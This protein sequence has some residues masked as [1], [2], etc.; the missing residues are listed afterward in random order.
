MADECYSQ[1]EN[2]IDVCISTG[3]PGPKG[4]VGTQTQFIFYAQDG[5]TTVSGND[6]SGNLMEVD[7]DGC[8]VS[9]NGVLLEPGADYQISPDGL[10]ITF[11]D[12]I[13]NA[14]NVVIVQ[15]WESSQEAENAVL[16]LKVEVDKNTSDIAGLDV[17][18]TQNESDIADLQADQTAQVVTTA[19]VVTVG[20]LPFADPND[21]PK[22]QQEANWILHDWIKDSEKEIADA[23]QEFQG[24]DKDVSDLSQTV[25]DLATD[26]DGISISVATNTINISKNASDIS[27]LQVDVGNI[28]VPDLGPLDVRVTDLETLTVSHSSDLVSLRTD[29]D[30]LGAPVDLGPLN[31]AISD[32]SVAIAKNASDIASIKAVDAQQTGQINDLQVAVGNLEAIDHDHSNHALIDQDNVFTVSQTIKDGIRLTGSQAFIECDTGTPLSVRNNNF[33][34]AV[35]N[36]MR[37]NGDVAIS[38][39]A[40][41]HVRG[42]ATDPNDGTCA[43]NVDYVN[44]MSGNIDLTDYALQVDLEQ[45]TADRIAG[46][47]DLQTQIDSLSASGGYNDA[48]IQPAIDAGDADTLKDANAYTDTA[49]GNITHPAP[50]D[51]SP[52]ETI[53]NSQAGDAQ[54]LKDANAYTDSA[55]GNIPPVDLSPYET[56]A[57]ST[58]ADEALQDQ[59]DALSA[60]GGYNDAWI[61]P[62]IDAGDADTL[63]EAN[64]YTDAAIGNIPPVDLSD[65]E[66]IAKSEADDAKTL[67]DAKDYT[68]QKFSSIPTPDTSGFLKKSGDTTTGRLTH[69]GGDLEVF[70]GELKYAGPDQPTGAGEAGKCSI[71]H[72]EPEGDTSPVNELKFIVPNAGEVRDF[73]QGCID[74]SEAVD[75]VLETASGTQSWKGVSSGWFSPSSTYHLTADSVTG[76]DFT[77]GEAITIKAV[78]KVKYLL[79][80]EVE[81]G[82]S[83][84]T[85]SPDEPAEKVDGDLWFDNAEDTM[86]LSVFHVDSSAWLPVAPPLSL[87]GRVSTGE[88]VQRQ[89]VETLSTLDEDYA[90]IDFVLDV[91]SEITIE[92]DQKLL[93]YLPKSGGGMTGTISMGTN[94]ITNLGNA[95]SNKDAVNLEKL[96]EG[97]SGKIG[98]TGDQYLPTSNWKIRARK[99]SDDGNYSYIDIKNDKLHLYH[100]ADP[101]NSEHVLSLGYADGRYQIAQEPIVIKTTGSMECVTANTPGS[102][103]FCGLYNTSPG[104]STNA[105]MYFGNWNA[106]MRVNIDGMKTPDG[107]EFAQGEKFIFNGYVTVVGY[108]NGKVYFKHAI[109]MIQRSGTDSYL[110]IHFSNRVATY[111]TGQ[112]NS[113]DKYVVMIEG[114]RNKQ[115]TTLNIPDEEIE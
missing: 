1:C 17:R 48:W 49:I 51:L 62:A 42:V 26:V 93:A 43:A 3:P 30:A 52:Y 92:T 81:D 4:G 68:D 53:V 57:N 56:I 10:T 65:Y 113:E 88:A 61:Q 46:D 20:A 105:N 86:Q 95:T 7:P 101:L 82:G 79:E 109:D 39:E 72:L 59:I 103:Q 24:L 67:K 31:N 99:V 83:N 33:S 87:E 19:D 75:L 89:I 91:K 21:D 38:L 107:A 77:D 11:T 6:K 16:D 54:T 45:E 108:D 102:K 44:Q 2:K 90:K 15:T 22:T 115:V 106:G 5:D 36:V 34:N 73:L 55:I 78:V 96:N 23:R 64:G 28:T 110:T 47:A 104:S 18:V 50:P 37:S 25:T 111:A 12:P 69:A 66:K 94:K 70:G 14:N 63:K 29:V 60:S 27:Q 58:A 74:E 84:V 8:L 76:D 114:Y 9:L 40:S 97:L 41:G 112:N 13:K 71:M 35:I 98:D 80:G 32:N 85:I 100:V